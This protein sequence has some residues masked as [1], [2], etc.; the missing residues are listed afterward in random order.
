MPP[1]DLEKSNP[2]ME[3]GESNVRL[4][5]GPG[6]WKTIRGVR[7]ELPVDLAIP[8]C[9]DCGSTCVGEYEIDRMHEA[10]LAQKAKLQAE[11]APDQRTGTSG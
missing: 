10:Y 4:V 11:A 7:F 2:C 8:T 1:L 9:P 3:C 5:S 6:R